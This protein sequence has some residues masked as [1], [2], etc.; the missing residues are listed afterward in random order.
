MTDKRQV[1]RVPQVMIDRIREVMNDYQD[2]H[3]VELNQIQ[4]M[5]IIAQQSKSY[6]Q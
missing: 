2:K 6:K 4:A 5:E 1:L 3:G